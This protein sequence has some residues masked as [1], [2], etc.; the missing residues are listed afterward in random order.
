MDI[1]TSTSLRLSQNSNYV[2]GTPTT[3]LRL[4]LPR[5]PLS[6][7][8]NSRG[9]SYYEVQVFGANKPFRRLPGQTVSTTRTFPPGPLHRTQDVTQGGEA[10]HRSTDDEG[11]LPTRDHSGGV[12]VVGGSIHP[13]HSKKGL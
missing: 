2:P 12:P 3:L 6:R 10:G 8:E 11:H 4:R 1:T 5:P 13:C 7:T 9:L